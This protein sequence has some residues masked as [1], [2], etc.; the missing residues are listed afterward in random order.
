MTSHLKN[1]AI[2]NIQAHDLTEWSK[3]FWNKSEGTKSKVSE[4]GRKT[5][6]VLL[7]NGSRE[8]DRKESGVVGHNR[9]VTQEACP[10]KK[11][12]FQGNKKG[13]SAH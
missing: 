2:S 4:R 8:K 11:Q 1:G 12:R 10:R 3:K 13:G 9:E 5:A 6:E 7:Q